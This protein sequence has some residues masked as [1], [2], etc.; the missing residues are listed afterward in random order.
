M[1][2]LA[3]GS[4][5]SGQL[6]LG[7]EEDVS[8]PSSVEIQP[9]AQI[10]SIKAGGNHT[11][12]LTK[13]GTVYATGSNTDGR[14]AI[15]LEKSSLASF[16]PVNFSQVQIEFIAATWEASVFASAQGPV[17]V[18]G[19][20]AKGELGLGQNVVKAPSPQQ[21]PNFPP[22]GTQIV[23]LAACMGHVVAVLSNGNVYG[24]G[25]GLHGQ[26][27]S[28]YGAVWQPRK[29]DSV[30]FSVSRAVCGKDFTCVF[31]D[32]TIGKLQMLGLA[33]RDRYGIRPDTPQNLKNWIDVQATWGGVYVLL[34]D[35][36]LV[37]WG[38]NDHGQLPPAGVAITAMAAGSEHMLVLTT[39][40]KVLAWGW[41]EH[42][43]CGLPTDEQR[44]VK[45]R[46]NEF[47]IPGKVDRIGAG[48]ATS[49][50]TIS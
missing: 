41:G 32:P 4:N 50:I 38:R 3:L 1:P 5:G 29:L 24:W 16:T 15:D 6:A 27:D 7:H 34:S 30:S 40:G 2:I 20:G 49:W 35:N 43:N 21:I 42:G 46:W 23:D 11:L 18:C 26:L 37:A 22:S 36:R 39:S 13:S 28:P 45:G 31:G 33:K 19:S 8:A 14:C 12:I 47:D 48:C 10:T 17:F 9:D 44:D 25:N